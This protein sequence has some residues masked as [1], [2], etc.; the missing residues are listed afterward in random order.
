M[1]PASIPS[2]MS[3]NS[4]RD[5]SATNPPIDVPGYAICQ[6]AQ[7]EFQ[8]YPGH[9]ATT[10]LSAIFGNLLPVPDPSSP[11]TTA[12]DAA[13]FQPYYAIAPRTH[14]GGSE[15][16]TKV[17]TSILQI[18]T[19]RLYTAFEELALKPDR[20]AQTPLAGIALERRKFF[21]TSHSNAPETTLYNTPRISMWPVNVAPS[22]RNAYDGLTAFCSTV[23]GNDFF[24]TRSNARS[25]TADL[26]PRNLLLYNYLQAV[27]SRNVPGFGGNFLA[28]YG[29]GPTGITDR[30]QLLT[31]IFDYIRCTN[32][33]D[34]SQGA[35]LF[36]PLFTGPGTSAYAGDVMPIKIGPT[37]GFGSYYS[38]SEACI[39]FFG[40]YDNGDD[41]QNP[42]RAERMRAIVLFQPSTPLHGMACH[43]NGVKYRVTGLDKF[44]VDFGAGE[45][46]LRLP[47]DGTN[48]IETSDLNSWHGRSVGG[49]EGINQSLAGKSYEDAD[50]GAAVRGKY[51][52]Y[53]AAD[54]EIP[55]S[56]NAQGHFDF[57]GGAGEVVVEVRAADTDELIQ[58]I[59]LEFPDAKL[60]IPQ[61]VG[62]VSGSETTH[63]YATRNFSGWPWGVYP[64]DTVVGLQVAGALA[65]GADAKGMDPTAG[66]SRMIGALRDVPAERFRPHVGFLTEGA[67]WGHTLAANTGHR[68][69][70]A[71]LGMLIPVA[72]YE[73]PRIGR[74]PDVP[75]CVGTQVTRVDGDRAT[76]TPVSAIKRTAPTSI[77]PTR[78]IQLSGTTR[79]EKIAR[80]TCWA[81]TRDLPPPPKNTSPRTARSPPP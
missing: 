79:A 78:A 30:D 40:T 80:P 66:D 44:K 14:V 13:K 26:T 49:A 46:S 23:A 65:G 35:T 11:I 71:Q 62:A 48:F 32:L 59:R 45:E 22:K 15:A 4:E 72:N 39:Q 55:D 73:N 47:A 52:F 31:C 53:S 54:I 5:F 16:G 2:K 20:T 38:I 25:C 77:N 63:R 19:D 33:Q 10:S 1:S 58:T 28:K 68:Y 50:S 12:A 69:H 60:K 17:S 56:A 70:G 67:Q 21:L 37:Q 43:R 74:Y 3:A 9:P 18:A 61:T 36:T 24:F 8:R 29:A 7:K 75:P 27:T 81:T 76:G 42:N 64:E 41:S 57:K 51:P 6:P 34:R